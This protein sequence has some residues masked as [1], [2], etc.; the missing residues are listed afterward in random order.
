M[1][2][3][4]LFNFITLL[5]TVFI[6]SCSSS[7]GDS[8]DSGGNGSGE[9]ETPPTSITLTSDKS[10]FDIGGTVNFTVITNQ[11]KNVTSEATIKV[12]GTAITGSTYTPATHGVFKISATFSNL[13]SNELSIT[14][15]NVVTVSSLT[16]TSDVSSVIAGD[17]ITFSAEATLSDGSKLD[18]TGDSEF[19]VDG[20]VITGN[21]YMADKIGDVKAKA[22]YNN[23]TSNELVIQVA[24]V[25]IPTTYTK[26]AII[27]DYTGTWC[28]WCP[29]VSYAI[30]LVEAETDKVFT[31]AAHVANNEPMENDASVA[32]RSAFG[33]SSFPTAYVNRASVWTYPE[34][35]NVDEAVNEA[36][37]NTDV[38]LA[39]NSLLTGNV[40]DIVVSTG[41]SKDFAGTKLVVFILE[42]KLIYNQANYTS[43]YSGAD[44]IVGFE[45]NH[46]LRYAA[47]DV[48]GDPTSSTE[49]VY[50][51]SFN[52][53]L[54]FVGIANVDNTAV[55]AMLVDATGK[56]VLNAQYAKVNVRKDFD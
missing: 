19:S 11:N 35:S 1:K 30:G 3:T 25:S 36:K 49:G 15:N 56:V 31:I 2:T 4:K 7:E 13:T 44:P 23:V 17:V 55:V 32:L 52:V 28:G 10:V 43:Y 47:T 54:G 14:V 20:T 45:H 9:E 21:K 29:R 51:T 39:I 42:D 26:K 27:E 48:L 8:G 33:V 50:H 22:V 46:V 5:A 16:I 38:G 24:Q 12:D 37:G 53:N 34:P 41:F 18:K 6:M 40:L